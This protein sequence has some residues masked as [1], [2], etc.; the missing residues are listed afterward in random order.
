MDQLFEFVGNNWW[1]VGI[2]AAF[3]VALL[4]DNNRRN[5]PT[6]STAEATQMINKEDALVLDIRDK[7]DFSG[8][9]LA[10]AMNIPYA[11]L[12]NRLGEL[13]PHKKRPIILIC[14][15]GQTVGMAG[16]MLREKG[17][18]AVRMKGGMMEWNTQNLPLVKK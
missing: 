17:F 9:H 10:G 5:G 13:D 18:N 6:V 4:W 16:K 11:S 14:K 1:L 8:G 3:V 12:A 7:K 2:W 15:T